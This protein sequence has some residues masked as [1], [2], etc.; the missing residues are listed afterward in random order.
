MVQTTLD[1]RVQLVARGPHDHYEIATTKSSFDGEYSANS[2]IVTLA[3]ALALYN[4]LEMVLLITSTFKQFRG[5]YFWSLVLCNFGVVFFALGMMLG[6][7]ELCVLWLSK[8]IIDIGWVFMILFQSLVLYSR[9]N[10]IYDERK[11]LQGVKWMIV[12][13]SICFLIPVVVL[14]FG[15]TYSG[16]ASFA[17]GYY[18]IE[19]IQMVGITLQE[20]SISGL[21]VYKTVQLLRIIEREHTRSMVWQLFAINV[22]IISMDIGIVVLQ[23][24][25][26]QLYQESI[27]VFVYSVKLKLELNI[28]SKLVDLVHG[29]SS[30]RAMTLD[31]IDSNAIQGQA[32]AD[33]HREMNEPEQ[34][35]MASWFRGSTGGGGDGSSPN[36]NHR[37]EKHAFSSLDHEVDVRNAQRLSGVS[38]TKSIGG[39]TDEISQVMSNQSEMTARTKGRESDLPY[40]DFMRSI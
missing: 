38:P 25:H 10:L 8:V 16:R 2:V 13:T 35:R 1:P 4:S 34:G 7:F 40:A 21:Y 9:L 15:S 11:I 29:D 36:G 18:Y 26:Y 3:V 27:K 37:D 28:L 31:V 5:L 22:I 17:E 20:L 19:Q 33:V 24:M 39:D 12:T 14:D 23:F 6:Y 30:R 32:R